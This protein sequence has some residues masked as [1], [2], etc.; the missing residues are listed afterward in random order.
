MRLILEDGKV[1][2]G[3]G[4]VDRKVIG[5]VCI[6][7][8]MFGY[9]EIVSN[10][11][12]FGKIV[13]MSYPLVGNVGLNDEDDESHDVQIRGLIVR[14]YNDQPSNFRTT[15]TVKETFEDGHIA[16]MDG[17]DTR[18]ITQYINEHGPLMGMLVSE[19]ITIEEA[20]SEIQG[21]KSNL[22]KMELPKRKVYKRVAN[23]D[24]TVII[25]DLGVKRS[26]I[27][28]LHDLRMNVIVTPIENQ[29]SKD[30]LSL[31]PDGIVLA[32]GPE[33]FRLL[34]QVIP[35]AQELFGQVP[36]L[37]LGSGHLA[38]AKSQNLVIE[39]M[40]KGHFGGTHP[41][42]NVKTGKVEIMNQAHQYHVQS[43][44]KDLEVS[45]MNLLDNTVEGLLNEEK[46]VMS[47]QGDITG[48]NYDFKSYLDTFASWMKEG[49]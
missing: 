28:A 22:P 33:D 15:T 1:F 5:E 44:S 27:Q 47:F 25:L 46:R 9:Q 45:H 2:Q 42:R 26:V 18:A 39:K 41:V 14:E 3:E 17:V 29:S 32:G 49:K 38:L 8:A 36:I 24:G 31:K 21:I 34:D 43:G 4:I 10:P 20:I 30:L 13:C 12:F 19:E 48:S 40:K 37:A 6:E 11:D 16:L 23:P 7:H 35:L